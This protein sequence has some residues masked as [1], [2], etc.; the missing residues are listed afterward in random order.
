VER[1]YISLKDSRFLDPFFGPF[2]LKNRQFLLFGSVLCFHPPPEMCSLP[3][4]F[5]K[6][7]DFWG[8]LGRFTFGTHP[9]PRKCG[10]SAFLALFQKIPITEPQSK[11]PVLGLP[12]SPPGFSV[13][14]GFSPFLVF[15]PVFVSFFEFLAF[16]M[17]Y[18]PKCV[19]ESYLSL[20]FY[21]L[22]FLPFFVVLG[23]SP[24]ISSL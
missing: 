20:D 15:L 8:F 6:E 17:F 21:F 22:V 7:F 23:P 4:S 1:P 5:L 24:E 18:P 16:N 10:I 19:A 9:T 14:G 13:F 11:T 2:L 3:L 12:G